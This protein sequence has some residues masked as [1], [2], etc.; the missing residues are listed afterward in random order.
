MAR[1]VHTEDAGFERV[2]VGRRAFGASYLLR[3]VDET[4]ASWARRVFGGSHAKMEL[5]PVIWSQVEHYIS[6]AIGKR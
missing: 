4:N 2:G 1:W 3:S 5:D 6:D